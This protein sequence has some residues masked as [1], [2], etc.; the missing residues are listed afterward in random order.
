VEQHF[1]K[2]KVYP[3]RLTS[4]Q[5]LSGLSPNLIARELQN[6]ELSTSLF[7]IPP[8]LLLL[9][10]LLLPFLGLLLPAMGRS[11]GGERQRTKLR[12]GDITRQF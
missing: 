12:D 1:D 9:L 3:K 10:L 11:G 7:C 5:P 8:P 2:V 6:P 4:Y